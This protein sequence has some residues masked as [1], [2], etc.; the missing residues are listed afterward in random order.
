M[1]K[2]KKLMKRA[3]ESMKILKSGK[4]MV[5]GDQE[6]DL[7][8]FIQQSSEEAIVSRLNGIISKED[9]QIED[10]SK[11][12]D[13]DT[14]IQPLMKTTEVRAQI[15][16]DAEPETI[17]IPIKKKTAITAFDFLNIGA[18]GELLRTSTLASAYKK[19][20]K[21]WIEI[22]K[23]D[24]TPF[25]NVMYVPNVM[26]FMDL[27]HGKFRKNPY[28]VNVLILALPSKSQMID[29]DH[30]DITDEQAVYRTIADIIESAARVGVKKLILDPFDPKI[31]NKE[32]YISSKAWREALESP[33]VQQFNSIVFSFSNEKNYI[34]FN[35][36][37]LT[38]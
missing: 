38:R 21:D 13:I 23:D 14:I 6:I 10:G 25:T 22:N 1:G 15:A 33:K 11:V 17:I 20:K 5:K 29:E 3:K 32:R 4:I 27:K 9:V 28:K 19:I 7:T 36:H 8:P 37:A 12:V 34:V 26:V 31:L 35:A 2:G 16:S 24:T 30:P 18:L